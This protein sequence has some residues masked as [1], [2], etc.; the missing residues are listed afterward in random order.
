MIV[1]SDE[2]AEILKVRSA[3]LDVCCALQLRASF[4]AQFLIV[5]IHEI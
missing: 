3:N 2:L 4:D 1:E 5:C